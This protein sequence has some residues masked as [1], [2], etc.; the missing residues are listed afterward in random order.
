MKS[1]LQMIDYVKLAL[2]TNSNNLHKSTF[3]DFNAK[4]SS[5]AEILHFET[6]ER[7]KTFS[8]K[9]IDDKSYSDGTF[10]KYWQ[11]GKNWKDFNLKD[12]KNAINDYCFRFNVDSKNTLI[13]NIEFGVNIE[14]PFKATVRNIKN[15]F[16]SYYG[17]GFQSLSSFTGQSLGVECK[18]AQFRIKIYSKTVQYILPKNIIR[19]EIQVKKMQYLG[20]EKMYLSE[21][22]DKTTFIDFEKRLIKLIS[23]IVVYDNSLN[24][25]SKKEKEFS[26]D[27]ANPNYWYNLERNKRYYNKKKYNNLVKAKS[28]NNLHRNLIDLIVKKCDILTNI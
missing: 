17:K 5:N 1:Y 15:V 16:I 2:S 20:K 24:G 14:V 25:L 26:K 9:V 3:L 13:H 8:F 18:F 6:K 11:N 12:L 4:I 19:F 10:H 21:L 27:V 23:E 7:F 22:L 28:V